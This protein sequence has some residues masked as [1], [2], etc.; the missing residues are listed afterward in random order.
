[1]LLLS[2]HL[3]DFKRRSDNSFSVSPNDPQEV[4]LYVYREASC[5]VLTVNTSVGYMNYAFIK[6]M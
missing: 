6:L 3:I 5:G 2:V 4:T 1:M